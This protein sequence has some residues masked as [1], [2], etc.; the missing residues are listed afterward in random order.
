MYN[1]NSYGR[2]SGGYSRS[3]GSSPRGGYGYRKEG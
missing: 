3:G 2:S 1:N